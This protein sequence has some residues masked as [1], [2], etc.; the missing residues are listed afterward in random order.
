MKKFTI[1]MLQISL[2]F[3]MM[4]LFLNLVVYPSL[5]IAPWTWGSDLLQFKREELLKNSKEY[6]TLIIGSSR[7][8]RQVNPKLLDSVADPSLQLK[9]YNMGVN[10]LFAPETFYVLDQLTNTD[11]LQFKFVVMELSKIRSIDFANFHTARIKY[12]YNWS[13]YIFTIKAVAASGFSIYEKVYTIFAHTV[14]YIDQLINLGYLTETAK[15]KTDI[16]ETGMENANT[17]T[18]GFLPLSISEKS[19]KEENT[20]QRNRQFLSDTS[21]VTRRGEVS[22]TQFERFEKNPELLK[23]YNRI[24]AENLNNMIAESEKKGIFLVFLLSPRID[25]NQYK[26]LLPLFNQIDPRHRIEI[27]DGR[28]FPELYLAENSFDGT[29]LNKVGADLYTTILASRLS[30]LLKNR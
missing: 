24:Y 26:E 28:K 8:Y 27:S 16:V 9:S 19:S 25:N 20:M 14:S 2:L 30:T 6:N 11:S 1:R 21:V 18:D 23:K 29:H 7:V 15:F 22:V 3:F 5:K 17:G 4:S 13:N 10:W 12:W